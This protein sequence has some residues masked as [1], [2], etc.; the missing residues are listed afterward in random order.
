MVL[1]SVPDLEFVL[2]IYRHTDNGAFDLLQKLPLSSSC[3]S[4]HYIFFKAPTPHMTPI[5]LN[6]L[7]HFI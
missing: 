2:Y 1:F 7:Q 6:S 3:F 4:L 5:K